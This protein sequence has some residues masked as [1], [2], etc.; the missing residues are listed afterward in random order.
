MYDKIAWELSLAPLD[1]FSSFPSSPLPAMILRHFATRWFHIDSNGLNY[2]FS[3]FTKKSKCRRKKLQSTGSGLPWPVEMYAVWRKFVLTSSKEQKATNLLSRALF[4]FP[5]RH[6]GSQ[7]GR[8][9]VVRVQKHGPDMRWESTNVL[10]T[11]RVHL[12][13]SSKSYPFSL[14]EKPWK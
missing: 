3:L 4:V 2:P 14:L 8:H 11:S 6:W 12:K 10:L 7:V 13:S 9:H 5:P 1:Q